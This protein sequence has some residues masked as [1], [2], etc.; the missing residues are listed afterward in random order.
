MTRVGGVID[1]DAVLSP[2]GT[3]RLL[4]T[5]RFSTGEGI[6]LFVLLNPSTANHEIDDPTCRRA[7]AFAA[8]WGYRELWI[9]NLYGARATQPSAL[10]AFPDPVGPDNDRHL[11]DAAEQAALIVCGWGGHAGIDERA[12]VVCALLRASGKPLHHMGLTRAGHPRHPLYLRADTQPE[13]WSTADGEA[14]P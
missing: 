13:V 4:L 3:Y 11:R 10:R 9:A 14:C 8:A 12:K 5:R 6:C 1:R 2:C 7:T